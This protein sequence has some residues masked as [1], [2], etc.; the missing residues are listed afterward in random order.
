MPIEIREL[1]IRAIVEPLETRTQSAD[2][3]QQEES[4][5]NV[6]DSLEQVMEYVKNINER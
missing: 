5:Q 4:D 2:V 3:N 6:S 1:V